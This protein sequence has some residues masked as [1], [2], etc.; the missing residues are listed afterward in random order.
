MKTATYADRILKH[1]ITMAL[2]SA[3]HNVDS[4]T[5]SEIDGISEDLTRTAAANSAEQVNTLL[6]LMN[7]RLAEINAR[8]EALEA[9][10]FYDRY[11][12]PG[13]EDMIPFTP[14]TEAEQ[15]K[16]DFLAEIAELDAERDARQARD[17][18]PQPP[19]NTPPVELKIEIAATM[20]APVKLVDFPSIAQEIA[21]LLEDH[22]TRYHFAE[23]EE[24]PAVNIDMTKKPGNQI[25][26]F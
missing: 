3:G 23:L 10:E 22:L 20:I 21:D 26:L 19:E 5:Y 6:E 9:M 4:D 24:S 16:N 25:R 13:P 14:P 1:Y 15:I 8:L 18:I 7:Q 12:Q 2:R 17:E 11:T